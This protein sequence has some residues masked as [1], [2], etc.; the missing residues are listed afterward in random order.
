M[1]RHALDS[2]HYTSTA[3]LSLERQRLFGKLWTFVG[4]SSMVRERNQFFTR[5]VAGVPVLIQRTDAG[6]RAFV[7]E[8]PHRLSS[9]QTETSGKRPLVCPYHAWSFGPE[10]EL[11]G[12]PN[13]GL[14]QFTAAEREKICLRK[15]H[16]EEVGQLLFLNMSD[17][18]IAFE[19]QFSEDFRQQLTQV[20]QHLDS[21]IIYS[22]H[23]VRYN[24]K[25][26]M[27]NVK[28]YNHVPFIH[29][30]SFLPA[31]EQTARPPAVAEPTQ[32]SLVA[33]MIERDEPPA[34]AALSFPTKTALKPC[35]SWFADLCE[36]YGED[37]AYYNWFIY[38]NVNFCSVKGQHFLLQQYDP[39]APGETDY[40]LWMMTARRK[41]A[42]TDFTALLGTLIRGERAVIAEDTRVLECLQNGLGD[43]S[44]RF[45]HGDYEH[46]LVAQH[47]WYRHAVLGESI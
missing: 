43:H 11:R 28:D 21:Q 6:I 30:K 40:H 16:I 41:D 17:E 5:N 47:L 20:S 18:P 31:L 2:S 33:D 3:T 35:Q 14:Y 23:R 24:W 39:V 13:Q 38:P 45:M 1:S 32:P 22:C 4:F 37:D 44:R 7:N 26:N 46:H 42:R 9:I 19:E 36:P 34:L 12:I 25:L 15:L 10:G 8:C 27:E 29:P